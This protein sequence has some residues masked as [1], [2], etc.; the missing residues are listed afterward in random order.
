MQKG[1]EQKPKS[2]ILTIGLANLRERQERFQEAERSTVRTSTKVEGN[3][4][5]LNNLAW[6]IALRNGTLVLHST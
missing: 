4:V 6:L 3:M 2:S 1:L 5:S